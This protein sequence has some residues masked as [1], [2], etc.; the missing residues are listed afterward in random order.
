MK[1]A[2]IGTGN[3]GQ[4]LAAKLIEVGHDVFMGTRNVAEKASDAIKADNENSSFSEWYKRNSKVKLVTFREAAAAGEMVINATRGDASINALRMA[5]ASNLENKILID[6]SNPLDFSKGIPPCLIAGYNNTNSLGE[7]IQKEF[8]GAKVVKTFNTMWCGL[9]VDP[10]LIGGGDH[11]NFISG[12]DTAAKALVVTLLYQFGW[13][14]G[15]IIDLGDISAARATESI[16]LIWLRI[17]TV[18]Q[19]GAFNLKIVF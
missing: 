17:M 1:I 3:V 6:V 5:G 13:Q 14:S 18:T 15:N 12:N 8:P 9:M 2:I 11:V 19:T 7:E 10:K 16:L 4:T